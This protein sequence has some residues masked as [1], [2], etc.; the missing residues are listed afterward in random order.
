V[1]DKLI[2]ARAIHPSAIFF[3][4]IAAVIAKLY[5]PEDIEKSFALEL[6][7]RQFLKGGAMTEQ[8]KLAISKYFNTSHQTW[9]NL[10]DNYINHPKG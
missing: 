1:T 5:I 4:E 6:E 2:P 3:V 9:Q 7:I 8:V 10:W